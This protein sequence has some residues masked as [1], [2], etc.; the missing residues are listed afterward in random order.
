MTGKPL[1]ETGGGFDHTGARF[2][3]CRREAGFKST[4]VMA[5]AGP[6]RA[7]IATR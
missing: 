4:E 5:L 3:S 6:T 1:I 7:A 2:G